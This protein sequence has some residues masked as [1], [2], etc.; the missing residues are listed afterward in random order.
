ML[1]Q[2]TLLAE[3]LNHLVAILDDESEGYITAAEYAR[4]REMEIFFEKLSYQ[5]NDFL[6]Q[7]KNIVQSMG[8]DTYSKG[9][10]LSLLHRTWKDMCF[11]LKSRD[12]SVVKTCCMIGEKFTIS[13]YESILNDPQIPGFIKNI[14]LSQ[15]ANIND[16]LHQFQSLQSANT[17]VVIK[18]EKTNVPATDTVKKISFL[19]IYLREVARDFEMIGE[20]IGDK[21]LRTTFVTASEEYNQFANELFCQSKILGFD[22]PAGPTDFHFDLLHDEYSN[23]TSHTKNTELINICD[24]SEYVFLKLYTDVLKEFAAFKP[25]TD[26]M[27]YQYNSIRAGFLKLRMLN[28]LRFNN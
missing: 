2:N 7:I 23:D 27:A 6:L 9:G 28:S 14:L 22:I 3:K 24:K 20:E 21:N 8:A 5:R 12:K 18:E 25:F 10:F 16:S 11:K 15:L 1:A 26:M 17:V 4:D 19:M 13:Y